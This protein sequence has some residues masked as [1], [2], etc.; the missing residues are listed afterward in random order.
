M[1]NYFGTWKFV[2]CT[3]FDEYLKGLGIPAPLRMLAGLTSPTLSIKQE[4]DGMVT[5]YYSITL[6]LSL[7]RLILSHHRC[8]GQ[9]RHRHLQA[10]GAGGGENCGWVAQ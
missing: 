3:N 8:R 2:E 6:S 10:G 5:Y 1:E 4:Q 9:G 7:S